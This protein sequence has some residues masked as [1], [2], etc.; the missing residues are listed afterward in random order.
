LKLNIKLQKSGYSLHTAS[1]ITGLYQAGLPSGNA[2]NLYVGGARF[3]SQAD[4]GYSD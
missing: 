2:V 1:N 4:A 3:E